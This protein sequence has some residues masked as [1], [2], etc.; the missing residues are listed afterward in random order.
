MPAGMVDSSEARLG[1]PRLGFTHRCAA[2]LVDLHY[3]ASGVPALEPPESFGATEDD[4]VGVRPPLDREA[5]SDLLVEKGVE[6]VLPYA[7]RVDSAGHVV[8]LVW[9]ARR[10]GWP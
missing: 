9:P 8:C 6:S 5:F 1:P 4:R 7:H 3:E 10:L 2:V